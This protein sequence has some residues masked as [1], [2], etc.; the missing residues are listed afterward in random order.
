M[1]PCSQTRRRQARDEEHIRKQKQIQEQTP[2]SAKVFDYNAWDAMHQ[3]AEEAS[4]F[5]VKN[6]ARS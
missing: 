5:K 1:R 2:R 6:E 4:I 3:E